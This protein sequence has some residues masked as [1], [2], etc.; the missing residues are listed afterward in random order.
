ML[1]PKRFT[2]LRAALGGAITVFLIALNGCVGNRPSSDAPSL[3]TWATGVSDASLLRTTSDPVD[4]SASNSPFLTMIEATRRTLVNDPELQS[5]LAH[6]QEAEADADQARL[7]PNPVLSITVRPRFGP[8]SPIISPGLSEDLI[9]ILERPHR[10]SAADRRLRASARDALTAALNT[11]A[12]VQEQYTDVQAGE[13]ELFVLGGRRSL[14]D[15]LSAL[16]DAR[17]KAGE[18][19]RLDVTTVEAQR[20]NLQFEIAQKRIDV[21]DSRLTLAR[22]MGQP[23]GR[24]DWQLTPWAAPPRITSAENA[25]LLQALQHRPEIQ[26]TVW[27]LAALG[28]DVSLARFSL[29]DGA[30][31]GIEAERDVQ[32]SVGPSFSTPVPLFDMGQARTRKAIAAVIEGRH[33]L[34]QTRRQVVEEVRKAH[35][36]FLA[37][38]AVLADARSKLLPLQELRQRQAEAAYRAGESDL[39][40]LLIAEEELQDTRSK[41][42]E[43]EQKTMVAFIHLQRAVGGPG[44]ASALLPPTTLPAATMPT[45]RSATEPAGND[46][47]QPTPTP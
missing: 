7:L 17:L 14:L 16:A 24:T 20:Q 34:T 33:K 4:V 19:S 21:N 3:I 28:D 46:P 39:T 36:T 8:E 44:V 42:V 37:T 43:F 41:L 47:S 2:R 30:S 29:F 18:G 35:S 31:F 25:W 32:W 40:T 1:I 23:G 22:L 12:E 10:A 38:Q 6:V 5:A 9:G 45:T 11:L 15:R 13:A 26:S 27:E